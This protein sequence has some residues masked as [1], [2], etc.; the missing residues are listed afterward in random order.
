MVSSRPRRK[1]A[2]QIGSELLVLAFSDLIDAA[3]S[4]HKQ[5]L[6][7]KH[8]ALI[9]KHGL[10]EQQII[11]AAKNILQRLYAEVF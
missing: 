9:Q 11:K 5:A 8:Q 4:K 6:L 2:R 7:Q 1:A 10:T 3:A